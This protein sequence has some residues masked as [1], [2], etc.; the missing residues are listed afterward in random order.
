MRVPKRVPL[1]V[2]NCFYGIEV[3]K[4]FIGLVDVVVAVTT[5]VPMTKLQKNYK[6][7]VV[8]CVSCPS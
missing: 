5:L 8:A 3:K 1:C 7:V 4:S 6:L 2:C